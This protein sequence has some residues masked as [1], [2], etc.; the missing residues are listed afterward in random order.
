MFITY[1][2]NG[3]NNL[4]RNCLLRSNTNQMISNIH[5]ITQKSAK[6]FAAYI[7]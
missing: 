3:T 1:K 4:L 7:L 5:I 6:Q 2:K